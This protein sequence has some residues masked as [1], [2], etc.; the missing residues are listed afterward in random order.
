MNM[1]S[2][3]NRNFRQVRRHETGM[4]QHVT[5]H[6]EASG[7]VPVYLFNSTLIINTYYSF[8]KCH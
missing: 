5:K 1:S 6:S 4:E 3:I 8:P 7:V 2:S